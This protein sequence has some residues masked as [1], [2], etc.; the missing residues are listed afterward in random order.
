MPACDSVNEAHR[1]T[2]HYLDWSNQ[3]RPHSQLNKTPDKAYAV[4]MPPPEHAA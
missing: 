4:M 2:M 1:L 3:A